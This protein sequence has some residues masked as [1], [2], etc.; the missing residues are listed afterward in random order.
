MFK[1]YS[2]NEETHLL[3]ITDIFDKHQ[4]ILYV[5]H[6]TERTVHVNNFVTLV[7]EH[8]LEQK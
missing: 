2:Y 7:V 4:E 5:H 6:S 8:W 3:H 1:D